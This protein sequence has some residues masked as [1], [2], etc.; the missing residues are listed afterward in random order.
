M[1]LNHISKKSRGVFTVS[2]DD[3]VVGVM[4][5]MNMDKSCF[6]V[7]HTEVDGAYEGR[8]LGTALIEEAIRY[9][10]EN[11]RKIIPVCPFVKSYFRKNEQ[12][13]KDVEYQSEKV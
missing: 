9:A 7:D 1:E 5:Y 3:R 10:R 13:I 12:K 2:E 6:I 4:T 11:D 8:G